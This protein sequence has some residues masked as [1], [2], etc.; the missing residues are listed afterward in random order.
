MALSTFLK[1]RWVK[2]LLEILIFV[3]IFL[4]LR[5]YMQRN[6][7]E[8]VAPPIVATTLAQQSFDL[9]QQQ[10]PILVHFWATWCGICK[11]EESSIESISQDYPVITIAMQSGSDQEIE[12]YLKERGL[13]FPVINDQMSEW[14][15]QYGV[16]GVP[17]SFIVNSKG[18][19]VSKERGYSTEWGLRA[20]LWFAD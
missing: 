16:S 2:W 6:M 20:R 14:V 19:I 11:L 4:V 15:R 3:V 18:E 7:V 10:K 5:A 13:S 1:K 9:S 12:A 17:A 8:G